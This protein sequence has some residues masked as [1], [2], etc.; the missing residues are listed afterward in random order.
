MLSLEILLVADNEAR[1]QVVSEILRRGGH[2]VTA[3]TTLA[4]AIE[5]LMRRGPHVDVIMTSTR[6]DNSLGDD[7]AQYSRKFAV[8]ARLV[9]LR[10]AQHPMADWD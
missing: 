4:G 7:I 9:V 6:L 1:A 3:A 10:A 8:N 5:T 2:R